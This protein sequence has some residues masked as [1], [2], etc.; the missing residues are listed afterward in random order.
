MAP[1]GCSKLHLLSYFSIVTVLGY[2]ILL[3]SSEVCLFGFFGLGFVW[4][5][6]PPN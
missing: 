4:V 6:F 1:A 5:F 3:E 2:S